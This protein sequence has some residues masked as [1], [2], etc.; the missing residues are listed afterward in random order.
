MVFTPTTETEL[1]DLDEGRRCLILYTSGTTGRAK[2]VVW[3][4][5]NLYAQLRSLSKAWQ[6]SADDRT[7]LVLPLHHVHGRANDL[8]AEGARMLT[9]VRRPITREPRFGAID[10]LHASHLT[11]SPLHTC[12]TT[13]VK[14]STL[15]R[16]DVRR[17]ETRRRAQNPS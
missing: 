9:S 16:R 11:P 8:P 4:F 6:W 12:C 2:G 13:H 10:A 7:L 1:P 14:H 15:G 5:A 17:R 3:T